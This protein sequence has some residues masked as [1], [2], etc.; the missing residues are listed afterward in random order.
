M[1]EKAHG[2]KGGAR[3]LR[4]VIRKEVEDP[5]CTQLV[6]LADQA[7]TVIRVTAADSKVQILTL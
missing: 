7:P 1:A 4:K 6:E 3:D 2:H 5:I